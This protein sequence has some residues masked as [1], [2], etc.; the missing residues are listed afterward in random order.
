M[1][2]AQKQPNL[3]ELFNQNENKVRHISKSRSWN[4]INRN[5]NTMHA[6]QKSNDIL[7]QKVNFKKQGYNK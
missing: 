6:K 5:K 4:K 3:Q 2:W 1:S 7:L